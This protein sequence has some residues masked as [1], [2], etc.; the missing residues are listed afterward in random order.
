LAVQKTKRPED[1][2]SSNRMF[3]AGAVAAGVNTGVEIMFG[4]LL[5]AALPIVGDLVGGGDKGEKPEL[6]GGG[7]DG[8]GGGFDIGGL[9]SAGL[10]LFGGGGLFSAIGGLFGGGGG[11]DLGG[12]FGGGGGGGRGGVFGLGGDDGGGDEGGGLFGLF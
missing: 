3:R 4:A 9:F 6:S 2:A 1:S 7:G 8:G 5:G 10:D 12:L 11:F